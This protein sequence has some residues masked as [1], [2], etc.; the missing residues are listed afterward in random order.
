[1]T[2]QKVYR[3]YPAVVAPILLC[4]GAVWFAVTRD[5]CMLAALPFIFLG[6][7]CSAPNGNLADGFR[8][9]LSALIGLAVA[10]WL[11]EPLGHA[12]FAGSIG[13]W[14]GGVIEKR[15]TMKPGEEF[16][17]TVNTQ[18]TI[19]QLSRESSPSDTSEES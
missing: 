8:A 7:V 19:E 2:Q 13:G 1:M 15:V 9:V 6:S 14:I 3:V 12:I 17:K 16:K 10:K 18:P 5:L 11:F 4:I